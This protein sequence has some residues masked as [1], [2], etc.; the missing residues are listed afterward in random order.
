[1]KKVVSVLIVIAVLLGCKETVQTPISKKDAKENNA[2]LLEVPR[3]EL[4][5]LNATVISKLEEVS[6][7]KFIKEQMDTLNTKAYFWDKNNLQLLSEEVNDLP[8]SLP[9]ELK[10][11]GILS[12]LNQLNTYVLLLEDTLGNTK[13]ADSLTLENQLSTLFKAYNSLVVQFN[14]TE[15]SISEDF[16]QEL[17]KAKFERD[18]LK[19][20][21]VA[22][23]F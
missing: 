20:S 9:K 10:N 17:E 21:E 18:S 5:V 22:P 6:E 11:N 13:K 16:K 3:V 15:N 8:K 23:L 4:L 12:R 2:K 1:M 14:E 7:F 19:Q